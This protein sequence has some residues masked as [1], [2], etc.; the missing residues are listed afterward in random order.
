MGGP[1]IRVVPHEVVPLPSLLCPTR[2]VGLYERRPTCVVGLY[3]RRPTRVVLL[4]ESSPT[5]I[6]P[7]LILRKPDRGPVG[8]SIGMARYR[9]WKLRGLLMRLVIGGSVEWCLRWGT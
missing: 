2:V 5:G 9:K 7:S 3:E 4:S 1:V 8:I 6:I